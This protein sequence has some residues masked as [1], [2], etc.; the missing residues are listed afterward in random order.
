M[1]SST[2]NSEVNRFKDEFVTYR[3]VPEQPWAKLVVT[4]FIILVILLIA[5][6]QLALKMHHTAG[7]YQTT[8]ESMWAQ[9]R[10]K[11]DVPNDIKVVLTGSS[12]T[13]WGFD[14]YIVAEHLGSQPLQLALPGTGP[15]LFVQ[16]IVENTDFDGL[17]IVGI[18]PF[19]FNRMDEGYFGQAAIDAYE[20]QSPSQY[21]GAKIHDFLSDYIAF[22]DDSFEL[23]E[24][25]NRYTPL[26]YR[27]G[28]I[29]LDREQWK[30]GNAYKHR[31]V[32]MWE[33]VEDVGSFDNTQLTNFWTGGL[34]REP[35]PAEKIQE[36]AEISI[37]HYAPFVEEMR[38]RGGDIVFI[39]MPSSGDYLDFDLKSDYYHNM[40]VPMIEGLDVVGINTMDYP[41]L[42]TELDIPEWSHLSRASQ[43]KFSHII[44]E[45]INDAYLAKNNQS[46]YELFNLDKND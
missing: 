39:R 44:F 24:L 1:P 15:A 11:L 45:T 19:L 46:I 4:S 9:E 37:K 35:P 32:E 2:S 42:S 20:N 13:L 3:P 23:P 6:E 7:T 34:E 38:S 18:A 43:D 14:I 29:R 21:T 28:S 33:P 26:P 16:D 36:M 8:H 5:W 27:E 31:L 30:L 17:L 25:L 41:E 22:L 12:R 40:W 10:R